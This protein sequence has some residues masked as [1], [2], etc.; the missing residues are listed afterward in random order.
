MIEVTSSTPASF[1]HQPG[2]P[3]DECRS[4]FVIVYGMFGMSG[5]I[6]G[7]IMGMIIGYYL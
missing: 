3:E 2:E 7:M 1:Y 6:V 4:G 5:W